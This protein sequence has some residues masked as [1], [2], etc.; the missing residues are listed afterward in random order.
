MSMPQTD[1][2]GILLIDKP[3]GMTSHDVVDGIRR[4]FGFKKVGHAGT[5]DP[6][7]TGLMILLI[8][9]ATKLSAAFLNDDKAYEAKIRLGVVSDTGDI[10]GNVLEER[11]YAVS[12]SDIIEAVSR[13]RGEI[14]Q[15]PP[16]FSAKRHKGKKLYQYARRGI[17]VEREPRK[18][19]VKALEICG[20]CLPDIDI[21]VT[22]SKG[23]FIRQLA[24]DIGESLG[25]GAAVAALRRTLSGRFSVG[26]AIGFGALMNMSKVEVVGHMI[27]GGESA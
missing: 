14:E 11:S 2:S 10:F 20:I 19:N 7:A 22:C 3:P 4:R 24:V 6:M 23:T 21:K 9:K 27:T 8:G 12:E 5:L 26:N 15:V 25:A 17:S 1:E 18:V 13:F 16:M